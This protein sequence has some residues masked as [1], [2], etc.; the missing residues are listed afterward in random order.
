MLQNFFLG[1]DYQSYPGL[2]QWSEW[3]R[4]EEG[5]RQ[6]KRL[7]KPCHSCFIQ[8]EFLLCDAHSLDRVPSGKDYQIGGDYQVQAAGE[9]YENDEWSPWSKC[10]QG[11][12]IKKR[13]NKGRDQ[14]VALPCKPAGVNPG[15]DYQVLDLINWIIQAAGAGEDYQTYNQPES[16]YEWHIGDNNGWLHCSRILSM[17][18]ILLFSD[19]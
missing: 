5:K 6:K 10:D 3:S 14:W 19:H 15:G 11:Q 13:Y 16:D 9:D 4:C 17:A 7:R 2:N 12:K 8:F 1:D 18:L